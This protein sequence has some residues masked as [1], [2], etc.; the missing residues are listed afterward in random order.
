[1]RGFCVPSGLHRCIVR[2]LAGVGTAALVSACELFTSTKA[3][4]ASLG[5]TAVA[6]GLTFTKLV[7]GNGH[8]CG[9]TAAG[10]ALCWGYNST[11]SLATLGDIPTGQLGDSSTLDRSSPVAVA[12]GRAYVSLAAGAYHTCGVTAAGAAYCWGANRNEVVGT[13]IHPVVTGQLGS[14]STEHQ[15]FPVAVAGGLS[16]A[17]ITAGWFHT[18]GLTSSGAAYCWGSGGL[19]VADTVRRLVPTPVVGGLTFQSI[20]AGGTH[21]CALTATG[22]AYCWGANAHGQL[23]DGTTVGKLAPTPVTGSRT[24]ASIVAGG[25]TSCAVVTGSIAFGA[26]GYCWGDNSLGGVG[27]GT[28]VSRSAPTNVNSSELLSGIVIGSLT[29]STF[30]GSSHACALTAS[31]QARCW[32]NNNAGQNGNGGVTAS[33]VPLPVATSLT[34]QSLAAGGLHSCGLT[35][36]GAAYCWGARFVVG[37]AAP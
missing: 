28:T 19:G 14:G 16:F 3:P 36:S 25:N 37:A 1:M 11:R 24:F 4:Q 22:T 7:A 29:A 27:D 26:G 20:S 21:T 15:F 13:A 6:G 32:G 34:F 30:G 31:G 18:C 9:L 12:V 35:A 23:G 2:T 10:A 17:R 8:T 33:L 5:P